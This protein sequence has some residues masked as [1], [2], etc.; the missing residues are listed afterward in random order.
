M[1]AAVAALQKEKDEWYQQ[2]Q[3]LGRR[4]TELQT[5]TA[6]A[7][8]KLNASYGDGASGVGSAKAE[9]ATVAFPSPR[10]Q[11]LT[12]PRSKAAGSAAVRVTMSPPA[13]ALR[14]KRGH[15]H[16]GIGKPPVPER[17][18]PTTSLDTSPGMS[19]LLYTSPSPRDRG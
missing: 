15:E 13:V 5:R 10:Q 17:K 3:L 14:W 2:S 9:S 18:L 19:C 1:A 16:K 7:E 8:D 12:G 4:V 11:W 6:E